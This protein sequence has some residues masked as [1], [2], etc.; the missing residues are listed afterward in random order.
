[1]KIIIFDTETTGLPT[2]KNISALQSSKVWPDLVA[3][4]WMV[5]E[6]K[7]LIQTENHIIKPHGWII[8]NN[9][10]KIHNITNEIALRD[11]KLLEEI[12][13]KFKNDI[14][15]AQYI[16]AHNMGFDRNVLFHAYKWRLN[17]DPTT[18]WPYKSEFCSLMKAT[19]EMK[20]PSKYATKN[21][22]Y[23]WVSLTQLYEDTFKEKVPPNAH[24]AKRDVDV[25][26]Q[27]VWKRWDLFR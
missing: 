14:K 5:F 1:M 23:K 4:C 12:L 26:Q 20:I 2:Q 13:S 9:S 11:G 10:I 15:D 8:P 27:I 6:D 22:P 24:D 21:D 18:F 19:E 3:I 17:I 25:L 16:I 7:N